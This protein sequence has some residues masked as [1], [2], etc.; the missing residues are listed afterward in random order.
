MDKSEQNAIIDGICDYVEKYEIKE[1][2]KEYLRRVVVEKPEDPLQYLIQSIIEDPY[3]PK[4]VAEAE[5]MKR[6]IDGVNN[7]EGNDAQADED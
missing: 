6:I 2:L 5:A 1:L 7:Q 4:V 3:V